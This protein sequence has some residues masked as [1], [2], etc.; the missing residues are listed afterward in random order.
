MNVFK[1]SLLLLTANFSGLLFAES[2]QLKEYEKIWEFRTKDKKSQEEFAGWWGNENAI[3]RIL[4]R[5]HCMQKGYKSLLDVGCGFCKDFEPL[6]KNCPQVHYCAL[7]IASTFVTLALERG[8]DALQGRVD[9]MPYADDSIELVYCRHLLE[10][11]N[12]YENAIKEMVR[13]ASKEVIIVFFINP[14]KNTTDKIGMINVGGFTTYQ[15]RYSKSKI[16]SFLKNLNKVKSFS[17]QEVKNKDESIL[18]II[19]E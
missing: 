1:Y 17:W 9:Q 12:S 16:E 6:K 3:S 2:N 10:H 15:N 7:D 18:H 8:I 13:V 19:V 11:L 5:L 14:E 4:V